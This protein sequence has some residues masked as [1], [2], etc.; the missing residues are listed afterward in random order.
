MIGSKPEF[1]DFLRAHRWGVLSTLRASGSPVSS[2]VAYACEG[3]QL[4]VSTP[5]RT[6]KR[7]S[8]AEDPRV[9]LCAISNS[10]P[11]NFVSVE[12]MAIVDI[13]HIEDSTRRVFSAIADVGYT[14]PEPLSEWLETQERVILRINIE[15]MYGVIR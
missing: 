14:T 12:G 5:G 6:F 8:V 2:M 11:F 7:K 10:E 1:L 13:D 9:S 4:V 15:R 3:N